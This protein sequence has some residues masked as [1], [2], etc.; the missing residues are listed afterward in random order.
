MKKKRRRGKKIKRRFEEEDVSI[1]T[2]IGWRRD[3]EGQSV[4]CV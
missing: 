2:V 1:W 4:G 3:D